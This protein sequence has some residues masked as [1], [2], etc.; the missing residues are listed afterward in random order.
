MRQYYEKQ[1]VSTRKG[2]TPWQPLVLEKL[3]TDSKAAT[4][5]LGKLPG[6]LTN[7]QTSVIEEAEVLERR[8]AMAKGVEVDW[9]G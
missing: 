2:T 1:D 8:L 4:V 6:S 7:A 5:K 3:T 9:R